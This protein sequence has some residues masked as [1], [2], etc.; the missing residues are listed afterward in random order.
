MFPPLPLP[1]L[2]PSTPPFFA[3][4]SS[5]FDEDVEDAVDEGVEKSVGSLVEDPLEADATAAAA[6]V[7]AKG[8]PSSCAVTDAAAAGGRAELD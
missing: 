3:P 4:P 1:L 8:W 7:A 5:F 2:L 6:G